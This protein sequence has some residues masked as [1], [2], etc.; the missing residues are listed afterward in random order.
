MIKSTTR[1]PPT[2]MECS[3]G[4]WLDARK[5]VWLPGTRTLA[6]ADLHLGYAWAHRHGGQLMPISAVEDTIP[7]L[8][9]LVDEFAPRELLLLGD[10]VHRAVPVPALQK[11]L[12]C[13]KEEIGTRTELRWIAGNHDRDLAVLLARAGLEVDLHA[14]HQLDGFTFVHGDAPLEVA[15]DDLRGARACGGL[16]FCGHE[17]PAITISDRVTTTLKCPCFLLAPELIVLPAFSPWAAGSNVRQRNFLSHYLDA[18]P[19][20]RAVAIINGKLLPVTV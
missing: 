17:H 8:A 1:K 19:P 14:R 16:I 5:A 18:S 6:V 9:A 11:E 2:Q 13:L 20:E 10:I 12:A 15:Q 4:I 7:R 3:P